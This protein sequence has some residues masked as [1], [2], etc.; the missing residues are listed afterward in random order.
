MDSRLDRISQHPA[1]KKI[2]ITLHR[3]ADC[4]VRSGCCQGCHCLGLMG[5]PLKMPQHFCR[6]GHGMARKRVTG[7]LKFAII[8]RPAPSRVYSL[9]KFL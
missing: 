9:N 4:V 1:Q 7:Q 2:L 8:G 6:H 3:G 5:A